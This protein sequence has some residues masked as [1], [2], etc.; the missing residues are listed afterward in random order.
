MHAL[1]LISNYF[2][3]T[4]MVKILI[5]SRKKS[6][7]LEIQLWFFLKLNW[8]HQIQRQSSYPLDYRDL[9]MKVNDFICTTYITLSQN[10]KQNPSLNFEIHGHFSTEYQKD[11]NIYKK[12]LEL[13]KCACIFFHHF[14]IVPY[15]SEYYC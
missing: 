1:F 11:Q 6:V 4:L 14:Q 3:K 12:W 9:A 15:F 5:L 2:F 8:G 10:F 7:Y 13:Q